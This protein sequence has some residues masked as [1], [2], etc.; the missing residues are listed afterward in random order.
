MARG[1]DTSKHPNRRVDKDRV[2]VRFPWDFDNNKRQ[3]V[4]RDSFSDPASLGDEYAA[5]YIE[6]GEWGAL[7]PDLNQDLIPHRERYLKL[8]EQDKMD[9]DE[10]YG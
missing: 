8:L 5:S 4:V 7:D 6:T 3:V 2:T 9:D 1:E 10:S